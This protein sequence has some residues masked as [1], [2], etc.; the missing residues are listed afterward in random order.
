V[1][2]LVFLGNC[3]LGQ[4]DID[5]VVE[6]PI[7]LFDGVRIV[8]V[9]ERDLDNIGNRNQSLNLLVE[10]DKDA[11]R[12]PKPVHRPLV[13][14][15]TWLRLRYLPLGKTAERWGPSEHGRTDTGWSGT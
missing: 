9:C 11:L 3:Y 2:I 7:L 10:F 6:I 12:G 1:W 5:T 13:R 15:A 14:G 4:V 8:R